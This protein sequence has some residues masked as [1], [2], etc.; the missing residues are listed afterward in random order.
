MTDVISEVVITPDQVAVAQRELELDRIRSLDHRDLVQMVTDFRDGTASGQL[1]AERCRQYYD[2][3]QLD[4]AMLSALR[5]ARQPRVIR[6]EIKPAINGIL[7]LIQQAKVDPKA[8]PRNPDNEE[9]ADV[10]SKALRFVADQNR[11][12][13]QKVNAAE[14]HLI[15]GCFGIM[16]EVEDVKRDVQT[17]L[18]P[19]NQLIY[20]PRSREADF[21]DAIFKGVGK[22]MYEGDLRAMYP[23]RA[24]ELSSS[25]SSNWDDFGLGQLFADK[26]NDQLG[27]AWVDKKRRRIFVIELYHR[28]EVW[29]RCVFY[30]GGYLEEGVSPYVDSD[31]IPVCPLVMGSCFIDNENQ[32]YGLVASMLSP[33]DEL[34]AYASRS[35]HLANSRQL[36]VMDPNFPPEVEART[37]SLEAAK[38]NGVIPA[39][40]QVVPTADLFT[41]IQIMMENARQALVRQAPTPAVLAGASASD[42]SGRSRL[43]LQQAGMTEIARA[44]GRLEDAENEVYRHI[45][46]RLRQFKREPWWVRTSGADTDKSEFVGINI[47]VDS[48]TGE[49]VPDGLPPE[50][51]QQAMA[52]GLVEVKN[53]LAEMDV[54]I[55]VETIPDTANLQAEQFEVIAPMLPL[56]AQAKGPEAAFKVGLALSSF[57]DKGRIKELVDA[58][59][60]ENAQAAQM[61]Q[62][63]Q[64]VQEM[65]IQL[66]A[67]GKR[68]DVAKTQGETE[69]NAMKARQ[70]QAD[71]LK[72]A[73][74]MAGQAAMNGGFIG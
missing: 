59:P 17:T 1:V 53:N 67:M 64:Q 55:E 25:F 23:D 71:I 57:P 37:A 26:P 42:Q 20:D 18:V 38:A 10:A 5:K 48:N 33:Q 54:D 62:M 65:A 22:W 45:W 24:D 27:E 47:L 13:R 31:G 63:Q 56:L 7:G 15:E 70:I 32:R 72:D 2:G 58:P 50:M 19:Y 28:D 43:V 41:G 49:P 74:E 9:Q 46:M 51:V 30:V 12:H 61:A 8:Y 3:K 34:N 21:S 36:Q 52:Q 14:N 4:G 35:L 60:E 69:L 39:G 40:W 6:N 16:V 68:A 66:E 11:M 44:L 29:R 73:A